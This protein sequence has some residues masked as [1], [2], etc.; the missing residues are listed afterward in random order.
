MKWQLRMN[1]ERSSSCVILNAIIHWCCQ[2]SRGWVGQSW[3]SLGLWGMEVPQRGP[4]VEP[5][6]GLVAKPPEAENDI[7]FALRIT[8][9][10][11]Y[12]PFYSSYIITFVIKFSRNSQVSDFRPSLYSSPTPTPICVHTS[13]LICMNLRIKSRAVGG[14]L[15]SFAPHGDANAII[16]YYTEEG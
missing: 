6:W 14:Q 2:E 16:S 9:V 8:L 13:H 1:E 3:G 4:G 11:A 5:R 15:P 12:C 10:N 7:N